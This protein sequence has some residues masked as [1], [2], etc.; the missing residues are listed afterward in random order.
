MSPVFH[1]NLI[2]IAQTRKAKYNGFLTFSNVVPKS[3]IKTVWE[4][5]LHI[6]IFKKIIQGVKTPRE[7]FDA[8][9]KAFLSTF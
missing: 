5:L 6:L 7:Q 4:S 8:K 2:R 3:V 1:Y 9:I